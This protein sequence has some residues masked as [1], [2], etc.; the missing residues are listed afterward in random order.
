MKVISET[1]LEAVVGKQIH[2][3]RDT[4]EP[5]LIYKNSCIYS[6]MFKLQSPSK[7]SPLNAICLLRCVFP[8]LKT[9]FEFVDSNA[10]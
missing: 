1:L 10:S 8:L 2:I 4:K 6:Y 7:Y 5:R 3:R 9:I